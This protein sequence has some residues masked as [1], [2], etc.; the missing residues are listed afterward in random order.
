MKVLR[1]IVE[2]FIFALHA[3][4]VNRLRTFLSLLGITIGIFAII[5]VL[6]VIDSLE[7]NVRN[8][9]QSLGNNVVY[10]QKWPWMPPEGE[11]YA[12]WKFMNRPQPTYKEYETIERKVKGAEAFAFLFGSRLQPTYKNASVSDAA[13]LCATHSYDQIRSFEITKGRY[14]SVLE[15]NQGKALA[16]IGIDVATQL[17]GKE[18]PLGKMIKIG[19][20]RVTVIGVFNREGKTMLGDESIDKVVLVPALYGRTFVELRRANPTIMIKALPN[21]PT[22]EVMDEVKMILRAERRIRPLEEDSFALN[23]LSQL[24]QGLDKIFG[25]INIAG[26]IIGGFSILVG[27]FGIANIMFVSV[28]ERTNMIGVQ[29]ALGAKQ[30]FILLQF[31]YES[32]ILSIV[33]GGIGLFLVFIGAISISSPAFEISV[34]LRNVITGLSISAAIGIISGFIPAYTASKLDPVEA[35]NAKV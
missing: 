4:S 33:G 9:L 24:S 12:W 32:V 19:R 14:F 8:S 5:S 15:A 3:A 7:R 1:Q 30:Y 17:F 25:I 2:S 13:V 16:I 10:V 23:Q 6:T 26:I 22:D 18:D 20:N 21:I 29:K 31:L 34:S 27:G 11:E 28:K 35:I